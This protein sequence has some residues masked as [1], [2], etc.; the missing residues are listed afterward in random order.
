VLSG[1]DSFAQYK[2]K[3]ITARDILAD[4]YD[5]ADANAENW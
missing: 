4:A 2:S 5:F 1:A 3:L